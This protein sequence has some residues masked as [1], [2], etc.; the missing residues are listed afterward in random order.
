MSISFRLRIGSMLPLCASKGSKVDPQGHKLRA[1]YHWVKGNVDFIALDH[2]S[3]D[4]FDAAQISP[5][6]LYDLRHAC[7]TRWAKTM[8]LPI[9]QKL[10]A[11]RSIATTMKYVHLHNADVLAAMAKAEEAK[12]EHTSKHTDQNDPSDSSPKS[13]VIN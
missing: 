11:H 10:A 13:C 9:V 8:P 2:A 5:F 4:Q 6:V 3:A 7:I 12:S 1:Y